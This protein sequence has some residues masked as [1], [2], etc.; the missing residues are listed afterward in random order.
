MH[1]PTVLIAD[2]HSVWRS[3]LRDL[4]EPTCD[5]V[6]EV[7]Q[8]GEAV[9]QALA[10]K[11]DVVLMDIGM[12]GGMDG[13]AAAQQIKEAL[14]E[15]AVVMLTATS[16]DEQVHNSICARV[17]GYVV[18]DAPANVI[19]EAVGRAAE[20]GAY[21]PPQ[22]ASRVLQQMRSMD[23]RTQSDV[24]LSNREVTVLRLLGEGYRHKEIA[25]ELGISIRTVNNHVAGIY[26][27]LG[28]SDRAQ[29]IVYAIKKGIVRL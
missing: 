15:T 22:I 25:R 1:R 4:L 17:S 27:K 8:G 29:A 7:G 26:N 10:Y 28:I 9:E 13:I 6:S 19:I 21:L 11:P 2:D 16:E 18:K 5:V 24:A 23:G 3:G 20:G 12:P 14:P